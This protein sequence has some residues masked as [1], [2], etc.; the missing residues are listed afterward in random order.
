MADAMASYVARVDT[1]GKREPTMKDASANDPDTRVGADEARRDFLKMA[2]TIAMTAPAVAILLR[3]SAASAQSTNP[4]NINGDLP[5]AD[6]PVEFAGAQLLEVN[7]GPVK[8]QKNK[9]SGRRGHGKHK[10]HQVSF[11]RENDD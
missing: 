9:K 10:K 4:Y 7:E 11:G 8:R 2:G 5:L 1:A 3:A 6:E